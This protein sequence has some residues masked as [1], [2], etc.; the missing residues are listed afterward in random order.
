MKPL[1]SDAKRLVKPFRL[2][3][4]ILGRFVREGRITTWS[5]KEVLLKEAEE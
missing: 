2:L 4:R 5:K 3:T 1:L